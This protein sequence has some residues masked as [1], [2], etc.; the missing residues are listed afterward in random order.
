MRVI[1]I[2]DEIPAAR[3]LAK[4]LNNCN[5]DIEVINKLDSVEASV[6]YLLSAP[7]VDLIFM[8]I[9][10]AD[11][12]SFD[13]F[14]Q[15]DLLLHDAQYTVEEYKNRLGWGHSSME[16]AIDLAIMAKV[17]R[18]LLFHHDPGHSDVWLNERYAGLLGKYGNELSFDIA[19]EGMTIEL[20]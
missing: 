7:A 2:E 18:L 12:I 3:R 20:E 16:D 15:V 14:D 4:L 8:D 5:E 11:G 13:I 17:K 6:K 9:Q 10:L 1:I 19:R